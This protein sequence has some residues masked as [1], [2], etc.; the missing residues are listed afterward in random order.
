MLR[1]EGLSPSRSLPI[2]AVMAIGFLA[3]ARLWN[4][5]ANPGGFGNGFG[6]FALRLANFSLYGGIAGA[7]IAFLAFALLSRRNPWPLLDA[8]VLP[9]AV[10]FALARVGCFLNGCCGGK[11]TRSW[12]GVQF[13]PSAP[14]FGPFTKTLPLIG[15]VNLPV[16]PTQLFEL[17]LAL[18][19]L[20]PALGL[21]FHRK[22][23]AGVPFL[24]Y[25]VWFTAMRWVIL[26]FR[27]LPYP[28]V[29]VNV[30]YPLVYAILIA[31][32]TVLILRKYPVQKKKQG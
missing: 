24:V 20:I 18:L 5:F 14:A 27:Y 17:A 1:R 3:G 9:V 30:V 4:W 12:I 8:L 29:V 19:G 16:Y 23:P 31:C 11:D 21:Y 32:G 28:P 2:L 15:N 7:I 22:A 25:G 13:P 10:A 6:L 26:Y